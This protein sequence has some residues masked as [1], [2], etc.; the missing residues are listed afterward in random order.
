MK[1][2]NEKYKMFPIGGGDEIGASCYAVQMGGERV[3]LD[4]GIRFGAPFGSFP[5]LL[6]F[7]KKWDMD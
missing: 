6:A 2:K 7:L 5:S 4:A 1:K 3:L